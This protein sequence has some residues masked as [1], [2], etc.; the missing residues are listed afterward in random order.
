MQND[1]RPLFQLLV[2]EYIELTTNMLE[3][4]RRT[5]ADILETTTLP[6]IIYIAE[7]A[8]ITGYTEKT[9]YSKVSRRQLPV[10]SS[11]RPLTF[12]RA[13]LNKWIMAGPSN[14]E[15][16]ANAFCDNRRNKL[17]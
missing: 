6:D 10:V 7:A 15:T 9:I 17:K 8:E 2:H 16:I 5:S 14:S 3:Q 13:Q 11:G 12:S 1:N 4:Y